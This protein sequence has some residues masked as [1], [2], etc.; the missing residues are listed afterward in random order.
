MVGEFKTILCATDFSEDS[1]RALEYGLRFAQA[2]DGTIL[3]AHVVHVASGELY[4][5]GHVLKVDDAKRRAQTMLEEVRQK[6]LAG[7]AKCDLIVDVGD[8]YETLMNIVTQRKVDLIVT[9][10]HGRSALGQLV[11]GSVAEKLIR[12]A[13]C[14]IFVMRRPEA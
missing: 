8:P 6:R 2:G 5:H 11:I 3:L 12:H 9:S 14:P 10:T 13:R 4:E 7:Y 1:Y